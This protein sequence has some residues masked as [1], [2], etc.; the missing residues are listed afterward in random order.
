[1]LISDGEDEAVRQ[2]ASRIRSK[3]A[4]LAR[5]AAR[6]DA[7]ASPSSSSSSSSLHA[8]DSGYNGGFRQGRISLRVFEAVMLLRIPVSLVFGRLVVCR[9]ISDAKRRWCCLWVVVCVSWTGPLEEK[10][11]CSRNAVRELW[12]RFFSTMG[13]KAKPRPIH[14]GFKDC[15]PTHP[16]VPRRSCFSRR[17]SYSSFRCLLSRRHPPP[18]FRH[19]RLPHKK[20]TEDRAAV[21]RRG[22]GGWTSSSPPTSTEVRSEGVRKATTTT[23]AAL[24]RS[25][26]MPPPPL[27]SALLL[28]ARAAAM[29][30]WGA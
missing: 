18:R 10:R 30:A 11:L 21:S 2:E 19:L 6:L 9:S 12:Q 24:V 14:L 29:S 25:T 28:R 8:S 5:H 22:W 4:T 7:L 20:A 23:T 15:R 27:I 26:T 17:H 13:H 1:M 3:I 16:R